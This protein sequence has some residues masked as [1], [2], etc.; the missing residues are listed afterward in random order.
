MSSDSPL[1][2]STSNHQDSPLPQASPSSKTFAQFSY[3]DEPFLSWDFSL[4]SA[5]DTLI[6]SVN[7]D[8]AGFG[9]EIFTDTG[10]YA[11][12]MDAAA[13]TQESAGQENQSQLTDESRGMTLDE[14]AVML[15]TA[16]SVDFDYFS[17]HS[18]SGGGSGFMGLAWLWALFGE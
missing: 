6:G 12:R 1:P 13:M 14:R 4:R 15:A 2:S 8:F 16:V 10:V 9:R 3:I 18:S 17:R 7:R 5:E 11:L